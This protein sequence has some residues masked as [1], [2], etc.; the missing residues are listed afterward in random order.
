MSLERAKYIITDMIESI[1]LLYSNSHYYPSV[2]LQYV[3]IDTCGWLKHGETSPNSAAFKQWVKDYVLL[4]SYNFLFNEDDL[5][6]HRCGL[7]HMFSSHSRDFVSGR[8]KSIAYSFKSKGYPNLVEFLQ[9]KDPQG[10]AVP[11]DAEKFKEAVVAGS[12]TF[13]LELSSYSSIDE[14]TQDRMNKLEQFMLR[15]LKNV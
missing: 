3:L 5:W 11:M 14:N 12:N 7:L 8:G 10:H 13:L 4:N 6:S 1:N 9:K 15:S 2:M